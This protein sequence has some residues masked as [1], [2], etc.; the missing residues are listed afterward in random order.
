MYL[1]AMAMYYY[2][3]GDGREDSSEPLFKTKF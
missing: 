3:Q 2:D 1:L